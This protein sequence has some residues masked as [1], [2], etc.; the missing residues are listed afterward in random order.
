M[1][2]DWNVPSSPRMPILNAISAWAETYYP[3]RASPPPPELATLHLA[4]AELIHLFN[5]T[6]SRQAHLALVDQAA[7][8]HSWGDKTPP[9]TVYAAIR[10]SWAR[11]AP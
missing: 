3:D 5:A 1:S 9:E 11:A 8:R 6:T 7:I 10:N 4:E 2:D